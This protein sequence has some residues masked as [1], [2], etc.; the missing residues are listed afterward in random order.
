MYDYKI[1]KKKHVVQIIDYHI[2]YLQAAHRRVDEIKRVTL[3][4]KSN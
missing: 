1:V 3:H 2:S 4:G